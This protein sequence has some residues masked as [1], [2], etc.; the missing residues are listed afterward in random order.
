MNWE[1]RSSSETALKDAAT[2]LSVEVN[3]A[4]TPDFTPASKNAMAYMRKFEKSHDEDE[5]MFG[6]GT[7]ESNL[8]HW[9]VI[10]LGQMYLDDKKDSSQ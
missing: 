7:Y 1:V 10:D 3:K 9:A 8:A 5:T 4:K 2:M 6:Q